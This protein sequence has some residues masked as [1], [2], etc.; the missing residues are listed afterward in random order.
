[1]DGSYPV[2]TIVAMIR[3]YLD[4]AGLLDKEEFEAIDGDVTDL[5]R[6]I[7]SEVESSYGM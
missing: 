7:V 4:Q 6:R 2:G 1:M 3:E 5:A